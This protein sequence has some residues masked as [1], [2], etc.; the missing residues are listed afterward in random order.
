[1]SHDKV[2]L[3]FHVPEIVHNFQADPDP[4]PALIRGSADPAS[5]ADGS[6]NIINVF[7]VFGLPESFCLPLSFD[8]LVVLLPLPFLLK[9]AA[10]I[11]S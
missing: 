9:F 1:M 10:L 5:R 8:P 3:L 7:Q 11:K 2:R 4:N 6:G